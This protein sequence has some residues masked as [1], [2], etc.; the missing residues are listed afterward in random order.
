M[1]QVFGS[2]LISWLLGFQRLKSKPDAYHTILLKRF[3]IER[4]P[5]GRGRH[6]RSSFPELADQW[7]LI[8]ISK[9]YGLDTREF[10]A[11]FS[12][13]WMHEKSSCNDIV[14]QCR[15]KTEKGAFFLVTRD[16]KVITQVKLS[17]TALKA[18]SDIDLTS[19]PWNESTL[20]EKDDLRA[21]DIR[22][23]D[24]NS[25]VKH[26][27]LK[28]NVVEKSMTRKVYSRA[29]LSYHLSLATISDNTGSIKLPLWNTQTDLISV[30]DRVQIENGGV[31]RFR[32]ELQVI[33]G[34][35]GKLNVI[36]NELA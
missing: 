27:N 23:K 12:D 14:I 25:R 7:Y 11:C 5:C 36:E 31:K 1:F 28:A 35:K 20:T 16:Q 17:E 21:I 30:G 33:V 24:L 13:A 18:L 22:I 3:P 32:G 34:K 26:F 29:G 15:Q 2:Q 19:Y 6:K 8:W 9:K 10:L 4:S